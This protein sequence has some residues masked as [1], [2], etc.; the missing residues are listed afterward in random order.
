METVICNKMRKVTTIYPHE[1]PDEIEMLFATGLNMVLYGPSG[2]GK[3]Q[4][5]EGYAKDND[6]MLKKMNLALVVTEMFDG[7]PSLTKEVATVNYSKELQEKFKS[8]P[9]QTQIEYFK[10]T[11]DIT[12]APFFENP[13]KKKILFLDEIT[14]AQIDILN[15]LYGVFDIEGKNWSGIPLVNTV[16]IGASNLNDGSD[17]TVYLQELPTPLH[18]R[19]IIYELLP[20]AKD[21]K[22]FLSSKYQEIPCVGRYIQA[23]L[24]DKIPPRDIEMALK[25]LAYQ[26]KYEGHTHGLEA[27]L[28]SGLA[29]QL[30]DIKNK[31]KSNDPMKVFNSAKKAYATFKE[32]DNKLKSGSKYI[33]TEEELFAKFK[34]LGLS[35]EEIEAIK[36]GVDINE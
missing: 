2:V 10:K 26:I 13:E 22:D 33:T 21:T 1:I 18:N 4:S 3:S 23:M 8:L 28:G 5:I 25:L 19:A 35:N 6:I 32:N 27:K 11:M 31:V 36:K 17:G 12:L 29:Q 34:E 7:I 9:A 24:D 20:N 30:M 16:V 15:C 14:Q